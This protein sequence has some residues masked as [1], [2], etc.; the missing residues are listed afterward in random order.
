MAEAGRR[1][2]AATTMQAAYRGWE[3]RQIA[4]DRCALCHS[5]DPFVLLLQSSLNQHLCLSCC[6]SVC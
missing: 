2:Q 6:L 4:A 1:E 3:G 5:N